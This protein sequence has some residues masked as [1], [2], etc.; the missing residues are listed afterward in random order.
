MSIYKNTLKSLLIP[1]NISRSE[2]CPYIEG[3]EETRIFINLAKNP[4]ISDQLAISGFRRVENWAYKPVCIDCD[5]CKPIRIICQEFL[6]SKNQTRIVNKN[7]ELKRNVRECLA[8][9]EHYELFI[10]YQHNRHFN[11]P[12]SKMEWT[13]YSSMINSSPV[14]TLILEYKDKTNNLIGIMI[15]DIQKN[16]ISAV[17]SFYNTNYLNNSIGVF[18][19]LDAIS[20]TKQHNLDFLYLG[21]YIQKNQKMNYKNKFFPSE[22]L[23]NGNWESFKKIK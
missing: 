6:F 10:K 12:M 8:K 19:I 2:N 20:Y 14:N 13:D 1:L 18:M 3:K 22:I 17:Y 11:G 21:Y 23:N 5:E 4:E 15:I 7:I 16:G 9:K